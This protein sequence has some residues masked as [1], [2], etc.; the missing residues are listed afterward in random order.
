M[1]L[2]RSL[3][4]SVLFSWLLT[5]CASIPKVSINKGI[6][7]NHA[8]REVSD[9]RVVHLPMHTVAS[10]SYI[11]ESSNAEIGFSERVF[12][13]EASTLSWVYKSRSYSQTFDLSEASKDLLRGNNY[14]IVYRIFDN[15]QATVSFQISTK[16]NGLN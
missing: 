8:N 16:Q 7:E 15:G 1:K 13:A 6:V 3:Y 10:F 14:I 11:L 9:V 5:S 2:F 12:V 4:L